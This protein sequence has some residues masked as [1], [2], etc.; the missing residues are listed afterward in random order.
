MIGMPDTTFWWN[1]F[2]IDALGS[3]ITSYSQGGVKHPLRPS[4]LPPAR[5]PETI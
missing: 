2:R 3:V 4:V 5:G 1:L